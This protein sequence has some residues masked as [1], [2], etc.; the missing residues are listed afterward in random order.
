MSL[1]VCA[2]TL[3]CG[4]IGSSKSFLICVATVLADLYDF[5]VAVGQGYLGVVGI[6]EGEEYNTSALCIESAPFLSLN[7]EVEAYLGAIVFTDDVIALAIAFYKVSA[8]LAFDNLGALGHGVVAAPELDAVENQ[9]VSQA[10]DF[11]YGQNPE[12]K[13]NQLVDKLIANRIV[14]GQQFVCELERAYARAEHHAR[15]Y[16]NDG[17]Y[18]DSVLFHNYIY[19]LR[20]SEFASVYRYLYCFIFFEECQAWT[21]ASTR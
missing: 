15:A 5:V 16:R 21:L 10:R 4:Q 17:C 6:D 9:N 20:M 11:V 8:V 13:E 2:D 14:P 18:T 1:R 12:C 3:A 19:L 7:V